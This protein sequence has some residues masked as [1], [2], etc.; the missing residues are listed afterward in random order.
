MNFAKAITQ[1]RRAA[2]ISRD[3]LL[4][5]ISMFTIEYDTCYSNTTGNLHK[6][7]PLNLYEIASYLRI[8]LLHPYILAMDEF[9]KRR[10]N[11]HYIQANPTKK[12]ILANIKQR[13]H[14]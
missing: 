12:E 6:F 8:S 7:T 11:L 14:R 3:K 4:Q 2:G 5:N 10:I 13:W 9:D 1:A